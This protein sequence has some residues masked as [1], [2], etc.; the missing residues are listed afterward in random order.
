MYRSSDSFSSPHMSHK[1][2]EVSFV[3]APPSSNSEEA[4]VVAT[5]VPLIEEL[6]TD[7]VAATDSVI[8]SIRKAVPQTPADSAMTG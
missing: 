6:G 8:G 3:T 7:L 2:E 4:A 5:T 1:N